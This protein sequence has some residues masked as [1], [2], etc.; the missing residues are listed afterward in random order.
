MRRTLQRFVRYLA[1]QIM[2]PTQNRGKFTNNAG[3]MVTK[4]FGLLLNLLL[5]TAVHAN[6]Q[7]LETKYTTAFAD[8]LHTMPYNLKPNFYTQH[9]PFFCRQ[10]WKWEQKTKI[11]LRF[12]LGSYQYVN[13]LEGKLPNTINA[14]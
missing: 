10:E 11:P 5:I 13:K 3:N 14:E 7:S 2:Q 12:R 1:K 9:L 8:T 6:A 4:V